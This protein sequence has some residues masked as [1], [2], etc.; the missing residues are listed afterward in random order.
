MPPRYAY[1]TILI[2]QKPTAFRA[3]EREELLPTLHQLQR[4]NSDVALK[5]FAR[6]Q[7]WESPADAQASLRAPRPP[8]ERR[9]RDWRPGGAHSDPRDRFKKKTQSAPHK[10]HTS[11]PKADVARRPSDA[12]GKSPR[13]PKGFAP[14]GKNLGHRPPFAAQ[15]KSSRPAGS[16]KPKPWQR[17]RPGPRRPP[18]V[19]TVKPTPP[20]TSDSAPVNRKPP[21]TE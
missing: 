8:V 6:G 11:S 5:W 19:R 14:R 10:T 18:E 16:L 15:N 21:E 1:W 20:S 7:L 4:K 13:G 3:R 9:G 17:D 2:D 12:R